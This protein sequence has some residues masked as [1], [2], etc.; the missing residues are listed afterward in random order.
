MIFA[1]A[2]AL[3]GIDQIEALVH[4][5]KTQRPGNVREILEWENANRTVYK[6]EDHDYDSDSLDEKMMKRGQENVYDI[7]HK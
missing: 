3:M 5:V 1:T 2:F 4:R 6:A 7:L